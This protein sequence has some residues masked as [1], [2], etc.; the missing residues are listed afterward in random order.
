M[1]I[2]HGSKISN[3]TTHVVNVKLLIAINHLIFKKIQKF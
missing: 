2:V 3:F 1:K